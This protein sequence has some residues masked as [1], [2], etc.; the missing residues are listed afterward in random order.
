VYTVAN[1]SSLREHLFQA[2][3]RY[4]EHGDL[5]G[6]RAVLLTDPALARAGEQGRGEVLIRTA[7]ETGR[8]EMLEALLDAGADPNVA[9]GERIQDEDRVLY[10]PGYVPLHYAARAGRKDMVDLLIARGAAPD[11]ED[12]CGGTP[13]HA[14]RTAEIV[15]ALV[16]AGANPNADCWLRHFD[17]T[18]N[19]HFVASPLHVAAQAG[20]VAR[21]RVLV[22][23]GANVDSTDGIT[24][25]TP[26][27]YAA[28]RGQVD[29]VKSLLKFGADPNSLGKESGR[30]SFIPYTPLHCAVEKG[31]REVVIALLKGGADTSIK[32]GLHDKTASEMASQRGY[33]KIA[34]ILNAA[35][36]KKRRTRNLPKRRTVPKG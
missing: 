11:A 10:Q 7:I 35:A 32:G 23:H 27:Y 25:R 22:S 18:L 3:L 19:W 33:H 4:L 2:A 9:E 1:S 5:Q 16:K 31:H 6:L 12:Y 24:G 26:L 29:A 21:I 28:A 15:E 13:L 30:G 17:E 14:A 34:A 20:D 8:L 36:T